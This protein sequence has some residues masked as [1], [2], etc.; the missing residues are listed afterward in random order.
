MPYPH[1]R[2]FCDKSAEALP[3]LGVRGYILTYTYF[4]YMFP[5]AYLILMVITSYENPVIE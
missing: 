2:G 1:K 4:P 5:F 3:G